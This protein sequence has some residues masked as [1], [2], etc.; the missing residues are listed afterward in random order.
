MAVLHVA[1]TV[2]EDLAAVADDVLEIARF[3]RVDVVAALADDFTQALGDS[4][5]ASGG[6][7]AVLLGA[8]HD[9]GV[10]FADGV[11]RADVTAAGD[12][13]FSVASNARG[14]AEAEGS[15]EGVV[16][17]AFRNVAEEFSSTGQTVLINE[18]FERG[19]LFEQG[20]EVL[21]NDPL[22]D[23]TLTML[24]A[25]TIDTFQ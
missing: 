22:V 12:F 8:S 11:A 23:C 5:M 24:D 20:V 2:V 4:C 25:L 6:V 21:E 14:E 9:V 17:G 1:V 13:L 15:T 18:A 10:D 16:V 3:V 19:V 7:D